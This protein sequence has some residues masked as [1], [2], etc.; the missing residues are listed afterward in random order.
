MRE[1][2]GFCTCVGQ[3]K[4]E[5]EW[6]CVCYFACESDWVPVYPLCDLNENSGM[7]IVMRIQAWWYSSMSRIDFLKRTCILIGWK[8]KINSSL[9]LEIKTDISLRMVAIW[10]V[11][12]SLVTFWA[13]LAKR[14]SH[15]WCT[16]PLALAQTV[17]DRGIGNEWNKIVKRKNR[18]MVNNK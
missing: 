15:E 4:G 16:E 3:E 17:D 8:R 10:S 7:V 11:T 18:N 1:H 6:M 13:S 14:R 5:C 9:T 12:D 2:V